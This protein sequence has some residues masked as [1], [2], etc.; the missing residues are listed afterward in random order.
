MITAAMGS[1]VYEIHGWDGW[2]RDEGTIKLKREQPAA[3]SF[4]GTGLRGE[5]FGNLDLT[6]TPALTRTDSPVYF[7]WNTAAPTPAFKPGN[8]SVRWSGK[9]QPTTTEPYKFSVETYHYWLAIG[10][11]KFLRLWVDGRKL[12]DTAANLDEQWVLLKAG[13]KYDIRIEA[14]WS[15]DKS[16]AKLCW[17]TKTNDRRV[18]PPKFL[19]PDVSSEVHAADAGASG[20]G[21]R[22]RSGSVPRTRRRGERRCNHWRLS[23]HDSHLDVRAGDERLKAKGEFADGEWHHVV[24]VS[25]G[26]QGDQRFYVDGLL[27]AVDPTPGVT[28]F[29]NI[30]AAGRAEIRDE[31]RFDRAL[32]ALEI[33]DDLYRR[34]V[35]LLARITFDD[36]R[37]IHPACSSAVP[38]VTV[39]LIGDTEWTKD[40]RIGG[41]L[42]TKPHG[43][44]QESYVMIGNQLELPATDYTIAFWFKTTDATGNLFCVVRRSP[45]NAKWTDNVLIFNDGYLGF[46]LFG[47]KE[48]MHTPAPGKLNDGQW[49]HVATTVGG[50][51]KDSRFY[52]DG[53]LVS[54]GKLGVRQYVS[55]RLGVNLGGPIYG[56]SGVAAT[57]DDFRCYGRALTGDTPTC[58]RWWG[59]DSVW[60][61]HLLTGVSLFPRLG[62]NGSRQV[63]PPPATKK[64]IID[65]SDHVGQGGDRAPCFCH[66]RR[67]GG[68]VGED[69]EGLVVL[70]RAGGAVGGAGV[71]EGAAELLGGLRGQRLGEAGQAGF[72]ELFVRLGVD[73]FNERVG[74]EDH[75]VAGAEPDGELVIRGRVDDAE[76]G[77]VVGLGRSPGFFRAYLCRGVPSGSGR[78]GTRAGGGGRRCRGR[79]GRW[80][81]SR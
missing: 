51:T 10:P 4:A 68:G 1:T 43:P 7:L 16:I 22:S 52:I 12:I 70:D 17:E 26:P 48:P 45:Y 44:L 65:Q 81:R 49:H 39:N 29:G 71:K 73:C 46:S 3:A 21:L 41:A 30:T 80:G 32:S 79:G 13:Q 47:Q 34:E 62:Q 18:I 67:G 37:G 78:R 20:V 5:Y 31:H 35:G 53:K 8:F 59:N 63:V 55:N 74:V 66:R 61:G 6:G 2:R 69:D 58:G 15:G 23:L 54:V 19:Y 57:F 42:T 28:A 50:A 27:R 56:Y 33:M 11:P 25:G 60:H 64:S 38:G 40:G 72:A 9:V 36:G 75:H 76:G 14:A 24:Y 77:G